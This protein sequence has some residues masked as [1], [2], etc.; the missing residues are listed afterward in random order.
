LNKGA[1]LDKTSWTAWFWRVQS[2][3]F[4]VKYTLPVS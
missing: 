1:P 2:M 3:N 4:Y